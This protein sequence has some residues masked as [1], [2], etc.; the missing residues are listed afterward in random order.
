MDNE[1]TAK[2]KCSCK[3]TDGHS[4]FKTQEEVSGA[5]ETQKTSGFHKLQAA[6]A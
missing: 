2:Y 5:Q 1:V 3:Y 6:K 4:G